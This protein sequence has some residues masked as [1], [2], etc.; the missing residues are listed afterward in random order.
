[1]P[2]SGQSRADKIKA[3][4]IEQYRAYLSEKCR[5]EHVIANIEKMESLTLEDKEFHMIA[6]ANEQ[7][8]KLVNKYCP[9]I[10]DAQDIN[11]GGQR[12]N[13]LQGAWTILPVKA[14][15]ADPNS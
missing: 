2:I 5:L 10:R 8:L 14:N 9:D 11:L 6:K 1:M 7:R 3:E 15:A 13:P 4:R 12:D